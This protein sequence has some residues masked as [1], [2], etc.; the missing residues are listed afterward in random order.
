MKIKILGLSLVLAGLLPCSARAEVVIAL[1]AP[2]SGSYAVFGEQLSHGAVQAVNDINS[3]GGVLGQKIVIKQFDDACDPKQAVA[4]ANQIASENIK[5][6]VGHFCSGAGLAAEKVFM[7][8]EILIVSPGVG[9]PKFTEDADTFVFRVGLRTDLQ[10]QL[11]ADYILKHFPNK[12]VAILDDKSAYGVM[13]ASAAKQKLNES[14]KQEVLLDSF[15]VG[16]KDYASLVTLLKQQKIDVLVVGGYHTEIGLITR[17]MH[18]Q[19]LSAVVI[20]GTTL[21]TNELWSITGKLGEGTLMTFGPDPRTRAEAKY[22]VT[23][24]RK[25][26]YEP[27]GYTIYAYAAAQ[28]IA[29]GIVAAHDLNPRDVAGALRKATYPTVIGDLRFDAKGDVQKPEMVMYRW[30]DGNYAQ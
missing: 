4:V 12:N 21:M 24:L 5:F 16:Q 25:S 13:V 1:V 15:S 30:H 26:G 27:E 2:L 9:H 8:N 22:A 28:V 23:S 6:V 29:Q 20:G 11:I 14:G 17:Q 7:E 19:N 10:G 18:E 3:L